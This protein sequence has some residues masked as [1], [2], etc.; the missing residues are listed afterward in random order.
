[1]IKQ[2]GDDTVRA[3]EQALYALMDACFEGYVKD[4]QQEKD[5]A[6]TALSV[7][8]EQRNAFEDRYEAYRTCVQDTLDGVWQEIRNG[9]VFDNVALAIASRITLAF[10]RWEREYERSTEEGA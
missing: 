1:M 3:F 9:A 5:L 8:R 2:P 7:C 6:I 10:D 4:L